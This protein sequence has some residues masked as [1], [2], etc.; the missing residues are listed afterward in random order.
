MHK[1]FL[2]LTNEFINHLKAEKNVSNHT[3]RGYKKDIEQ[4]FEFLKSNRINSINSVDHRLI[5]KYSGSLFERNLRRTSIARK[6]ASTR[7]FFSFL[8]REEIIDTNPTTSL[9]TPKLEKRLPVFLDVKEIFLLL[10][11]PDD[12]T[13]TGIRNRAILEVLYSTGIRVSEL[14]GLNVGDIDLISGLVKVK[15]KGNKERIVPIGTSALNSIKK[16]EYKKSS[17]GIEP[18]TNRTPLFINK[19]AG[20][21]TDRQVRRI[22]ETEIKKCSIKR[23][24]SPHTLRHTFATHMLNN[25]AD[26]RAVQELL[27]HANLSTTQIY[28]HTTTE[29]LKR[30]YEKSHPRA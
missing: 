13:L 10:E 28:L 20:R 2:L 23:K 7:T 12:G 4:F 11:S 27:G 16:Y 9:R 24:A 8:V 6:L 21:L 18:F 26:L 25:G 3:I 5:R 30:V 22:V 29:L 1:S 15:G 14:V 19:R 17:I